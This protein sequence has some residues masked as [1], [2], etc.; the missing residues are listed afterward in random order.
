MPPSRE[1]ILEKLREIKPI[2]KE[3][4]QLNEMALFG[5][6]ARNEQTS[7]SD[8][9]IMVSTERIPFREYCKMYN[10]IEDI[11]V[12]IKVE[13]VS[14]KAIRPQYFERMKKDLIYA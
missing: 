13:I 4:Y 14:R 1:T 3:K 11:F 12:D 7:Q 9:D 5:S 10:F 6:Y 8:L 2:L